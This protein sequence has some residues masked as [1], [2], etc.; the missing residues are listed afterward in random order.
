MQ[1]LTPKQCRERFGV[2]KMTLYRWRKAG[3]ITERKLPGA[4]NAPCRYDP[5]EIERLLKQEG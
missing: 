1:L 5:E 4:K 3:L 2:S